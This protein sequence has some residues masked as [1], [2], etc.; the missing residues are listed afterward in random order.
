MRFSDR[1]SYEGM[2]I[3]R[4]IMA[5]NNMHPRY[6]FS[7]N[8]EHY[9]GSF[10]TRDEALTAAIEAARRS[11]DSPQTV[12]V[13]RR[14]PGD[15][16]AAGHARAILAN[17]NARARAEFGDA[18]SA[19]L[20]SLSRHQIENLDK[21]LELVIRGWLEHNELLP[22]FSKLE[23]ISQHSVPSRIAQP[24]TDN[25]AEVHEIGAAGD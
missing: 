9:T 8:R 10:A 15:P 3:V 17:M 22:A 20:A 12:Y 7:L 16:M 2:R 23:S 18:G 13:G 21:S 19:Y 6:A 25:F 11:E 14:V 24:P 5:E 4:E 1:I